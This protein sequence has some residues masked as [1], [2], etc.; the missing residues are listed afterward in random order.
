LAFKLQ[1]ELPT[2]EQ[3]VGG[4]GHDEEPEDDLDD[5]FRYAREHEQSQRDAEQSE[6]DQPAGTADR[7]LVPY[8][9]TVT[10]G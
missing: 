10:S 2:A 8:S 3:T 7:S 9:I 5:G 6:Q 1:L 4:K